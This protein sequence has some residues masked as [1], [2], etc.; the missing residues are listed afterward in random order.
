LTITV[1][2]IYEYGVLRP[3]EPLSLPEGEAVDV[4][5]ATQKAAAPTLR[6]ATP[7]EKDYSQRIKAAQS[8]EEIFAVMVTAPGLPD[9]Y[10]LSQA[11][12]ANRRA[13]GERA[14]FSASD[15]GSTN[16]G[17]DAIGR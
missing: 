12:N 3:I 9:G 8:L 14:P 4:I 7:A 10:D 1:R 15:D 6:P 16:H 5:I 17:R 2:A 11:L 13:T